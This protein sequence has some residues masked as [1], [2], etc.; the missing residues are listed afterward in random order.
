MA[1]VYVSLNRGEE[2]FANADFTTG[3]SSA[4]SDDI[5]LRITD[6]AGLTRQDVIKALKALERWFENRMNATFPPL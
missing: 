4:S 3:A 1:N 5:E 6:A 2:G